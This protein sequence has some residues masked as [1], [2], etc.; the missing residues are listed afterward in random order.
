VAHYVVESALS[1]FVTVRMTVSHFR[2]LNRLN[3]I[4]WL[5]L[6]LIMEWEMP[7]VKRCQSQAIASTLKAC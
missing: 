6:S 4:K 2:S 5:A 3:K 7:D 1:C